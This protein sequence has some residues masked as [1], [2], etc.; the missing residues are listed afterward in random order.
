VKP[1]RITKEEPPPPHRP[2][3]ESLRKWF[4]I[5]ESIKADNRWR[6]FEFDVPTAARDLKHRITRGDCP[7][8]GV[9]ADWEL[10]ARSHQPDDGRSTLY[11]K[12]LS[13]G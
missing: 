12:R 3:R 2:S 11:V 13:D 10:V 1:A 6:V 7:V 9:I 8:P 4:P 5:F